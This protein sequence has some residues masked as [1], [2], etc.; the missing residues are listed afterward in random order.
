MK[1]EDWGLTDY[2]KAWRN[3]EEIFNAVIQAKIA[4]QDTS[5]IET[6]VFCEH[7]HVYTLGKSG[8]E[9]NLLVNEEFLKSKGATFVKID[10]GGDITY[11]GPGQIV[12]YPILNLENHN[13]SLKGYIYRME[14]SIIK[15]LEHYGI[16]GYRLD[17]AT[18]VWLDIDTDKARKICAVGVKA[19]RFVTMHGFALN[20]NTN[21]DYFNFIN[22]CGF[23][24]KGVTS[25]AKE[26]GRKIDIEEV[27]SILRT[28]FFEITNL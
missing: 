21:L 12:G 11:H 23:T 3:Q 19:S 13:L 20:V 14:E 9:S 22:P 8:S 10:R 1:F 25:M 2:Q 4:Q 26:L 5:D 15:T 17:G 7:P 28:N 27:K 24:T 6:L 18:G 16:D